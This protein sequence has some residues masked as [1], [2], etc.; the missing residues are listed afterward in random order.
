MTSLQI[1]QTEGLACLLL[2]TVMLVLT[3]IIPVVSFL[4]HGWQ[5][6]RD[7]IA[8]SLN[9]SA[10]DLYRRTFLNGSGPDTADSTAFFERMY[11]KRY[12][13][14][15]IR[16]PFILFAVVLAAIGFLLVRKALTVLL[17]GWHSAFL[18]QDG[19]LLGREAF[20]AEAGAYSFVVAGLVRCAYLHA[21]PPLT[22]INA[23]LRLVMG[24]PLGYA[25]AGLLAHATN[26]P[27][28]SDPLPF[29]AFAVGA[30]PLETLTLLLRRT[31]STVSPTIAGA[32]PRNAP[33]NDLAGLPG[34]DQIVAEAL[35][36]ENITTVLQLAYCDP[37]QLSL[38]TNLAFDVVLDLQSVAL[39]GNYFDKKVLDGLRPRGLRGAAEISGFAA[40]LRRGDTG[41][42]E[43]LKAIATAVGIEQE[44]LRNGFEEIAG[45]PYTMFIVETWKFRADGIERGPARPLSADSAARGWPL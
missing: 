12:G 2:G 26:V 25:V 42:A 24:I 10:I 30:V 15:R 28:G 32:I 44:G 1:Q 31:V 23:A 40:Q 17:P 7:D 36:D 22:L 3:A 4:L 35:R 29:V 21:L 19:F 43:L 37:I 5:I 14:K 6:K 20:F 34:I 41:A 27:A 39:A 16:G 13:K 45:D 9:A 38:R 18:G 8:G 11:E 33:T